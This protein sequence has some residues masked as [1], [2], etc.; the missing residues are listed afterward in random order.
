MIDYVI[1]LREAL[2]HGQPMDVSLADLRERS[3]SPIES[4]KAVREV[5]GVS[6]P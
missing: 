2:R 4:I 1:L 5:T 3:A 6:L